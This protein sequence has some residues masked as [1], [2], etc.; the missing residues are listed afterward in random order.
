MRKRHAITTFYGILSMAYT[1]NCV[2][3]YIQSLNYSLSENT[4]QELAQLC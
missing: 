1:A 2:R 3:I 4:D